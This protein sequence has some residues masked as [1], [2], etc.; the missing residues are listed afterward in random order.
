MGRHGGGSRGGGRS[1]GGSSSSGGSRSGGSSTR[2][3]TKPFR[4]GY[5]RCYYD[6][7]GKFHSY[8]TS[9]RTFGTKNGWNAGIIVVLIFITVHMLIMI[10]GFGAG[11]INFG[12]KVDGDISRVKIVDKVDILTPS[13]EEEIITLF[14]DVYEK[15]GM[16]VTLYTD[17]FEWKKRYLSLETYSEELY[18]Q[19]GYEEDAMIIL[20]TTNNDVTFWDWEYDMYCGDDTIK[21]LSDSAFDTLLNNFQKAM[22]NQ[23]LAHAL[24]YA[25]NSIMDDLAK[26][27]MNAE[28]IIPIIFMLGFYSIF[29]ITILKGVKKSNDAYKYFK[30][31]PEKLYDEKMSIL[32]G[33]CPNCGAPNSEQ[34]SV[35]PYCGALL[36]ISD[37]ERKFVTVD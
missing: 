14:N 32:Y 7:Y 12:G 29:Y 18:Y 13:E 8:Y 4:G 5:N 26:T 2:T 17:D 36:T 22:S 16:P 30:E 28:M 19:M 11:A 6:K 10:S 9:D 21:C 27:S 25:W 31:N 15:S 3:S 34:K 20:F 37:G 24:D 23:N 35:C 33:E 1:S